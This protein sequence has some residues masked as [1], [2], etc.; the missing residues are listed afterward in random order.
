MELSLILLEQVAAMLIII[1]IGIICRKV[2]LITPEG[3]KSITNLCLY[4]VNPIVIIV[5]FQQ[6][7]SMDILK[8]LLYAFVLSIIGLGIFILLSYIFV[9][10]KDK[11]NVA[12]ER[13]NSIY[14]NCGFMG[15]PLALALFGAEGVLYMTAINTVFNILVWTHNVVNISGDKSQVS[16]KKI[17]T[18]PNIIATVVGIILFVFNIHIP[19][20]LSNALGFINSTITPLAMIIAGVTIADSHLLSALKKPKVYL[21]CILKL[22]LIPIVVI[23]V[24][25]L[26]PN[27]N[28]TAKIVTI[29][30]LSCPAATINTMMS[31]RFDRNSGYSSEL[32]GITSVL[33]VATLPVII[34]IAQ[35]IG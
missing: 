2:N 25:K 23:C 29:I 16:L 20:P 32:F 7:F 30:G 26:L 17:V 14:S 6:E 15:I 4:V 8:G 24:F 1:C 12:I 13:A 9:K 27:I 33:S 22:L 34:Y 31:I 21:V 19:S 35:F 3:N 18:N 5:S 11:E 28:E 10:G